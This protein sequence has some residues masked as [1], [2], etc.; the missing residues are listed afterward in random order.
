MAFTEDNRNLLFLANVALGAH[1]QAGQ[2]PAPVVPPRA[3]FGGNTLRQSEQPVI[4][5]P[6]GLAVARDPG[7]TPINRRPRP[8]TLPHPPPS[9]L[10]RPLLQPPPAPTPILP[11]PS[12]NQ[13][14]KRSR[15]GKTSRTTGF[16]RE[17]GEGMLTSACGNKTPQIKKPVVGGGG[18][19]EY[20]CPRCLGQFTR[21][22]NVKDHFVSCVRK[23]GN[24]Q[25]FHWFDHSTLAATKKW[26]HNR[27]AEAKKKE[28]VGREEGT[29]E[30]EGEE[31]EEEE[32]E[33][34][35]ESNLQEVNEDE[36]RAYNVST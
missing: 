25:G 34:G 31:E 32:D 33:E 17:T 36:S 7:F 9:Q 18:K 20:R 29:D 2:Q 27:L 24:P 12:R 11:M 22:R 15:K 23:H 16:N 13:R 19:G 4:S 5:A 6:D 3:I 21:P 1:S 28:R 8:R 10:T 30:L 26:L 14:V 35:E